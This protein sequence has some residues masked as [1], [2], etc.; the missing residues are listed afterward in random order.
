MPPRKKASP[1]P[2]KADERIAILRTELVSV[3]DLQVFHKNPRI[4]NVNEIAKSL[5]LNRQ[6]KPIVVNIGTHTGR[7]NEILAGN[8]TFLGAR[9]E[10]TWQEGGITHEKPAWDDIS[11]SFVDVDDETALRIN[12]ADNATADKGEYDDKLLAD[13]IRQLPTVSGTGFTNDEATKLLDRFPEVD[14]DAARKGLDDV[15]S[16]MPGS[17]D[18]DEEEEPDPRRQQIENESEEDRQAAEARGARRGDIEDDTEINDLEDVQAELQGML[19]LK[20]HLDVKTSDEWGILPLRTDMLLERLPE[21]LSVW[22]GNDVTPDDGE[23]WYLYNYG[24]GGIKGLPLDRTILSFFTH[25][26]KFIHWYDLPSHYT[27]KMLN[28]GLKY[29]IV[30]DFS[31]YVYQPK[32]IHLSNVYMAQWLGRYFQEAGIKVIPRVQFNNEDSLNICMRG[33]PKEPP[34]LACSAQNFDRQNKAEDVRTVTRLLQHCVDELQ[35]QN[36]LLVYGGQPAKQI[37]ESIKLPEG[38]E[39]VWV[40]NY[41]GVRRGKAYDRKE[42][43]AGLDKEG[44][45]RLKKKLAAKKKEAEAKRPKRPVFEDDEAE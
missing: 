1:T 5:H 31:F 36:Q 12:L 34:V 14:L 2:T 25:D 35:P 42:G 6:F 30:P 24:L 7:K 38:C 23:K 39:P 3:K 16:R 20:E 18:D 17:Y 43:I 13:L 9:K 29:A 4:G 15:M 21:P 11:A 37:S 26:D 41:A 19:Q 40:E 10:L 8:H 27:A 28:A 45:K 32:C 22:G 44:K 33:I